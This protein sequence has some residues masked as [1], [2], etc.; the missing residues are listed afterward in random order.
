MRYKRDIKMK[1]ATREDIDLVT[2]ML[3]DMYTE[4]FTEA[5]TEKPLYKQLAAKHIEDDEVLLDSKGRGF[6]I[7][8]DESIEVLNKEVWNGVSVYIYPKYRK[9]RLLT[10]FYS[11]MFNNY[12][13]TILG[14]TEVHSEHNKVLIKRHKLLGYVYQMRRE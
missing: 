2:L 13:G 7:M 11:Y 14:F 9:T 8:R 6:F 5:S 10:R 12:S 4:L 1:K 3:Y